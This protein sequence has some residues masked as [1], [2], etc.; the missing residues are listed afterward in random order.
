[1]RFFQSSDQSPL[2]DLD[3]RFKEHLIGLTTILGAVACKESPPP[4]PSSSSTS[5]QVNVDS[6]RIEIDMTPSC[7][8]CRVEFRPVVKLGAAKDYVP[9]QPVARDSQGRWYTISGIFGQAAV[10]DSAGRFLQI[11]GRNGKGPGEYK[12]AS[13]IAI[14]RG[15]SIYIHDAGLQRI[16]VFSPTFEYVRELKSNHYSNFFIEP[17]GNVVGSI[18]GSLPKLADGTTGD[19][20][21]T[22]QFAPTELVC[23]EFS[24]TVQPAATAGHFWAARNP[25]FTLVEFDEAGNRVRELM[26]S[27]VPDW[28]DP[29][30]RSTSDQP[31]S[32][33]LRMVWY[34]SERQRLW[35]W[36][37]G[38]ADG[39]NDYMIAARKAGTSG[40]RP[41]A[42]FIY[43]IL[44]I[45]LRARR[46][47]VEYKFTHDASSLAAIPIAR[48][49]STPDE[50]NERG[51]V[52]VQRAVLVGE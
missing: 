2:P 20:I 41:V 37:V 22:F 40:P 7:P 50:E 34:D 13:A 19:T 49:V 10:Y 26:P 44:I 32:T 30:I 35:M 15:D 38:P 47:V 17:S 29:C 9:I 48:M 52:I 33:P 28:Y 14:G 11:I 46:L 21:R 36:V 24:P 4:S 1:V 18:V 6:G 45:D 39:W 43:R 27:K 8:E 23:R 5:V 3:V 31:P 51:G 42:P 12:G 16:S 25:T